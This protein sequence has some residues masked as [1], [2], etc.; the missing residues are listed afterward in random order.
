MIGS[1]RDGYGDLR[2]MQLNVDVI[3][4][5]GRISPF[6]QTI[7]NGSGDSGIRTQ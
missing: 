1:S 6:V 3:S 4:G 5:A 2:N 7:D